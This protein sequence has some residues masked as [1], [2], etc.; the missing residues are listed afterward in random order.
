[1]VNAFDRV[2]VLVKRVMGASMQVVVHLGAKQ[3]G[4]NTCREIIFP[5]RRGVSFCLP[6]RVMNKIY[7]LTKSP[8]PPPHS[9]EGFQRVL[10]NGTH[11]ARDAPVSV[12]RQNRERQ[13]DGTNSGTHPFL[14]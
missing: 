5:N 11:Q 4:I 9:R 6:S 1:M 14:I 10:N 12:A 8:P 13:E 3:V 2:S 7:Y